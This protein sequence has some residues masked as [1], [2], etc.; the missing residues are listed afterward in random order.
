MKLH[1]GEVDID[2]DL[3][4]RLVATQ[5]PRFAALPLSEVR[6]TGTV[7]AIYRLGDHHC[8]RLPRLAKWEQALHKELSWLPRLAPRLSLR[9]PEPIATGLPASG[10]PFHWAIYGWIEGSPYRDDLIDDERKAAEDL[11][12]FVAELR[13]VE[14]LDAPRGGRRPLRELDAWTRAAITSSRNVIDVDATLS[15]WEIALESPE[16]DGRPEWIH[17]D[18]LRPNVLVEAGC[19]RAV[20]DFGGVGIGDPAA[21]L[22]AAWS[23]FG[24]VGRET[25][26]L[27]LGADDGTWERARGYALHQAAMIIPYYAQTNPAFVAL[28]KR[29]IG[30][31]LNDGGR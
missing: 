15:A 9:V 25:F 29:T 23:V 18:L 7:N 6:S 4:A 1:E 16:W 22:I 24:P 26:R 30:E 5:F 3:V 12:R 13:R 17:T 27:A 21:D 2:T 10:Y 11:A 14:T 20:I 8:V 19:L 28:A 31:L